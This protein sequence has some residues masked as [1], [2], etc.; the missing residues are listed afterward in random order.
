MPAA[1]TVF[2]GF[3]ATGDALTRRGINASA[4]RHARLERV[5]QKSKE[6]GEYNIEYP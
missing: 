2:S 1:G 5:T 4:A 6:M 3:G